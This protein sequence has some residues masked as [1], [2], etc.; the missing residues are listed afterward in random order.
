MSENS[1]G[2]I[3]IQAAPEATTM[4]AIVASMRAMIGERRDLWPHMTIKYG[5]PYTTLQGFAAGYALYQNPKLETLEL[6]E[7]VCRMIDPSFLG[8]RPELDSDL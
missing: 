2:A 1:T 8:A 7:N 6:M 4:G 3:E 5:V